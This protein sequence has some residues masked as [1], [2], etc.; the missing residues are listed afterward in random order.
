MTICCTYLQEQLFELMGPEVK[1]T[2]QKTFGQ[3]LEKLET[4]Q[5][6]VDFLEV[7]VTTHIHAHACLVSTPSC[8][9]ASCTGCF[10]FQDD[11]QEDNSV[12]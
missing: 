9:L 11:C 8:M 3:R 2:A 10:A 12:T 4:K 7:G 5:D 6:L 1:I